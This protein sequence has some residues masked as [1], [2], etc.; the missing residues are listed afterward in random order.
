VQCWRL[1]RPRRCSAPLPARERPCA[2]QT[3]GR[4][5][6]ERERMCMWHEP[7]TTTTA[8]A[9]AAAA[10]TVTATA[11]A[12]MWTR[13]RCCEGGFGSWRRGR[14]SEYPSHHSLQNNRQT[15]HTA[16]ANPRIGSS[17]LIT[18]QPGPHLSTPRR[19][20]PSIHSDILLRRHSPGAKRAAKRDTASDLFCPNRVTIAASRPDLPSRL[21]VDRCEG[22]ARRPEHARLLDRCGDWSAQSPRNQSTDDNSPT[23][24]ST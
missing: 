2:K 21:S 4:R 18:K 10:A 15:P 13:Q 14:G 24:L 3:A 17:L 6:V 12:T 7:A 5:C 19:P 1:S 9:A 11:T 16:A 20:H 22:L 8:T 23:G